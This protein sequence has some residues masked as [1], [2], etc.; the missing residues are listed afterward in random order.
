MANT[1]PCVDR[2]LPS[3]YSP[4]DETDPVPAFVNERCTSTPGCTSSKPLCRRH[5][6]VLHVSFPLD[7]KRS[8]FQ[9][10]FGTFE[11]GKWYRERVAEVLSIPTA[12]VC[13][14]YAG[15]ELHDDRRHPGLA[16]Q[17]TVQCVLRSTL[18]KPRT[19]VLHVKTLRGDSHTFEAAEL[20]DAALGATV[21]TLKGLV[22]ERTDAPVELQRLIF[23]GKELADDG[24]SLRD[25]GLEFNVTL[26]LV[27]PL[28]FAPQPPAVAKPPF[29]ER[30]AAGRATA[31]RSAVLRFSAA[32]FGEHARLAQLTLLDGPASDLETETLTTRLQESALQRELAQ[33]DSES[34][35]AHAEREVLLL[36]EQMLETGETEQ[37][38]DCFSYTL[39]VELISA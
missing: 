16:M 39:E 3:P 17:S 24:R 36:V 6:R 8:G 18:S 10:P 29:C 32:D 20:G 13:L 30:A 11:T 27:L 21:R 37:S 25:Y 1:Y 34:V 14:Q 23:A 31:G 28:D 35:R 15:A 5:Q 7:M 12:D 22:R 9:I 38:V 26:Q 19:R 33:I 4:S 2:Y